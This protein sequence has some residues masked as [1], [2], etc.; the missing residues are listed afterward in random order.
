MLLGR[1]VPSS[2]A[3]FDVSHNVSLEFALFCWEKISVQRP[4]A[5]L[6]SHADGGIASGEVC[7]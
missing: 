5:A 6:Y 3:R 4:V 2:E 7:G 1:I